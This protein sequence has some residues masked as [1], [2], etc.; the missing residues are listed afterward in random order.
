M[1][2]ASS[3][4][5]ASRA[6]RTPRPRRTP[7]SATATAGFRA[8][9]GLEIDPPGDGSPPDRGSLTDAVRE[10]APVR[11]PRRLGAVPGCWPRSRSSRC[12]PWGRSPG[13]AVAGVTMGAG[14]MLVGIAWRV[15]GGRPPL[16]VLATD[17]LV[18]S[19]STFVGCRDRVAAVASLRP[20]VRVGLVGGLL[21]GARQPRWRR[22]NPGDHRVR[23]VRALQPAR[24]RVRSGSPGWSW[25]AACRQVLF[26]GVVR[27][28]TPLR[29]QRSAT[30]DGLPRARGPGRG[31]VGDL[32]RCRRR[33]ALD[34]AQ[35]TLSSLTLFGDPALM[36]LRSLVNEGHRIRIEL[37]AIHVADAPTRRVRG[38]RRPA[39][40]GRRPRIR[41]ARR[42]AALESG[43]PRDRGR[44]GRRRR[45]C[46]LMVAGLSAQDTD[47][48]ARTTGR[49]RRRRCPAGS[50]RSPGSCARSAALAVSAGEGGSLRERRPRPHTNRPLERLAADLAQLRANAS[51]ESPA[52]RH[53]LRLDRG[54]AARRAASRAT[55]RSSAA[56][57]WSWRPPPRCARSSAPRSR[58]APSAR[59][60]TCLGVGLAGAIAVALHPAGGATIVLVGLLAC[61]GYAVFPASFAVGFAFITAVVVFLLNAISPDTLAHRLG[62]AA[63]HAG[64]RRRSACSPTRCGRPGR[65]L[66]ARQALADLL[67][68]QRAYLA[69]ILAR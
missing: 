65:G 49:R 13:R 20:A 64:R 68:A 63:R 34:E 57:G 33:T 32:D 18:M 53:A 43:R 60:G 46:R 6:R 40:P 14:A 17:A 61:A 35:T 9:V 8:D 1:A 12:S 59:V 52:G 7:R 31:L 45:R 56:T 39:D 30:A 21:V 48:A 5:R 27:W 37:S 38:R 25:P 58:A 51:L 19:L 42:D 66:P 26:L 29:V 11:P 15:R 16:A 55:S 4:R 62:A 50:R 23:R 36:T 28:P 44:P 24:R 22:R 41:R 67:A 10:A 54:R 47:R 3:A 2:P 69:A